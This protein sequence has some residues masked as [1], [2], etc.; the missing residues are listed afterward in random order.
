MVVTYKSLSRN[1]RRAAR[2]LAKKL[3][4]E[5]PASEGMSATSPQAALSTAY[6]KPENVLAAFLHGD[7]GKWWG[8]V[9]VRDGIGYFQIGIPQ[10]TPCASED[11]ALAEIKKL[12]ADIKG[13]REHPLVKKLRDDGFDP[14][15]T[16]I[17]RVQHQQYGERWIVKSEQTV[18]TESQEFEDM[19]SLSDAKSSEAT[20]HLIEVAASIVLY[21][22]QEFA[23]ADYKLI[24]TTDNDTDRSAGEMNLWRCACS[25]LLAN[26]VAGIGDNQEDD[27]VSEYYI[28]LA[29]IDDS[30]NEHPVH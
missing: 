19:N 25:F 11:E 28:G 2:R 8:N 4:Q 18:L 29:K 16:C 9:A 20:T 17:L 14:A 24:E 7:R 1:E 23:T 13:T 12:I 27:E 21:Y 3:L 10:A 22:A 6:L 15:S 30:K 26:G 5:V